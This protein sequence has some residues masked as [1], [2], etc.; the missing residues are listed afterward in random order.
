MFN[1]KCLVGKLAQSGQ[2]SSEPTKEPTFQ[3]QIP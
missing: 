1:Q 2:T 3:Q